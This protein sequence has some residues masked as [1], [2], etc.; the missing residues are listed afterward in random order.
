MNKGDIIYY[1]VL[2]IVILGTVTYG[3][4]AILGG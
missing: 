1:I 4:F 3:I 2:T